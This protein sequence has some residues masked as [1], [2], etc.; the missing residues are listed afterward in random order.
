VMTLNRCLIVFLD[1]HTNT[2]KK[3][4]YSID[5]KRKEVFANE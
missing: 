4:N 3:S 2:V 1:I 5:R